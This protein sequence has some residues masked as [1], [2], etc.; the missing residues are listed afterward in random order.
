MSQDP[1][2]QE[3]QILTYYTYHN[4]HMEAAPVRWFLE[5]DD[6]MNLDRGFRDALAY[7][8]ECVFTVCTPQSLGRHE[9]QLST[10]AANKS[11]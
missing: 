7:T 4:D 2:T 11:R 9:R 10:K 1:T 8:E 5:P 6:V 3:R